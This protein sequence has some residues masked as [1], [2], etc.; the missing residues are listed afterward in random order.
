[1]KKGFTLIEMLTVVLIVAALTAVAVPQYRRSVERARMSEAVQMLPVIYD[2]V[3]RYYA[4]KPAT[5][6]DIITKGAMEPGVASGGVAVGGGIAAGGGIAV[7]GKEE[8]LKESAA[9][10]VMIEGAAEATVMPKA[11][12]TTGKAGKVSEVVGGFSVV[13]GPISEEAVLGEMFKEDTKKEVT[14]AKLDLNM[15]GQAGEDGNVWITP[16]FTYEI[17]KL[18]G[19]DLSVPYFVQATVARGKYEGTVF[20]YTGTEVLCAEPQKGGVK[21]ACALMGMKDVNEQIADG[22]LLDLN[23]KMHVIDSEKLIAREQKWL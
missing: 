14:F 8:N 21:G 6:E 18:P 1:M 15:K 20:G 9:A 17:T 13:A 10:A 5:E 19:V 3:D 16:N 7:G 11:T 22:D 12:A 2:A 23:D 4:A